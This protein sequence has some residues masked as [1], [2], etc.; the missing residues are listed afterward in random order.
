MSERINAFIPLKGHSERVPNKNLRQF[1]GGPLFHTVVNTLNQANSIASVVIDTDSDEIAESAGELDN[2]VVVRRR[3][4]QIGDAVPVND[5]IGSYLER[6]DDTHLLQTHSTNPVLTV[7]TI[8]RAVE[9]YFST[10][11]MTSLFGVTRMQARFYDW[12]HQPINHRAD[13][14]LPT[15]ELP[16]MYLENSCLYLFSREGFFE[17]RTRITA[18]SMLFEM[19]QLEA[20]DIDEE[21]DFELAE[22]VYRLRHGD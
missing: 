22:A 8:D 10:P 9:T 14:L 6:S 13:E 4:D 18:N 3:A 11:G 7:A 17:R 20:V 19:D 16:P 12:E 21:V 5:L 15:Q 1:H 2:V